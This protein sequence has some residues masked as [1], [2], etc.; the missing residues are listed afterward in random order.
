[1]PQYPTPDPIPITCESCG[2]TYTLLRTSREPAVSQE[3]ACECGHIVWRNGGGRRRNTRT[4][5]DYTISGEFQGTLRKRT[6]DAEQRAI[7][8][9]DHDYQKERIMGAQTGDLQCVKCG[10]VK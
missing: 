2:C 8:E 5:Q 10:H 6:V 3:L 4:G 7:A 9:C 1:M